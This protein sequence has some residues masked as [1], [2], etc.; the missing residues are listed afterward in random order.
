MI[1]KNIFYYDTYVVKW[2]RP[3][4]FF[5]RKNAEKEAGKPGKAGVY[6]RPQNKHKHA[7][8][9]H[10]HV[11]EAMGHLINLDSINIMISISSQ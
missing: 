5:S 3:A 9:A 10:M 8:K 2:R 6:C 7:A 1:I 4:S 11:S